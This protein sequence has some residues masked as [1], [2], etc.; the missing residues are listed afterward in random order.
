MPLD[1]TGK[2]QY[3]NPNAEWLAKRSEDIIEPE[4][5]I[6]DP[7]HHLWEEPGKK[8]FVDDLLVDLASGHNIVATVFIQA[9]FG[10]HEHGPAHLR[11]V[12]ETLKVEAMRL[13]CARHLRFGACSGIVGY[14]DLTSGEHLEETLD[15]HLAASPRHF[16][17]VRQSV[18]RDSHFPDGIVLRPATAGMMEDPNFRHGVK[19]LGRR[20]LSFDAML[21]HEQIPGLTALARASDQ[22]LIIVDHLAC[23]IGVGH[24]RGREQETF[25]AWRAAIVELAT[26]QNVV[27][28]FGGL[29]M[30]ILGAQ[31]HLEEFPPTSARLA[32]AWRPYFDACMHSFGPGRMMFE[33]NFPVDKAMFSYAV[34]WNAFK[35]LAEELSAAERTAL[36]S[37][38][39]SRVYRLTP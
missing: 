32:Q 19:I 39:A 9:H 10:Y 16:R 12:G 13:A 5:P 23:P 11:S 4:L 34:L 7:H 2:Y 24:Y 15:A 14:A 29:G 35:R 6:V 33:S 8:Y 31:Y 26:C 36:F 20:G 25:N 37:A 30:V 18:A 17:G 22:T 27:L 1:V 38:T 28:K 3:P 21:Y